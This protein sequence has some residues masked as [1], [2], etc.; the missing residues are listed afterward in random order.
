MA[1]EPAT[2][3]SLRRVEG[4]MNRRRIT[5]VILITSAPFNIDFRTFCALLLTFSYISPDATIQILVRPQYL[6]VFLCQELSAAAIPLQQRIVM[7]QSDSAY[8]VVTFV[9]MSYI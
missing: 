9:P 4:K 3:N 5:T 2:C 8:F 7:N 6:S 1:L